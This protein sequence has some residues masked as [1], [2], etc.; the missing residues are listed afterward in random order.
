MLSIARVIDD[1]RR[2][3]AQPELLPLRLRGFSIRPPMRLP[4]VVLRLVARPSR[5]RIAVQRGRNPGVR[6]RERG[7]RFMRMIT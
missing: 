7:T 6:M 1:V 4:V 5:A 2:R 3:F